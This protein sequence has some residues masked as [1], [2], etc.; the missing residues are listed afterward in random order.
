MPA[1]PTEIQSKG[2]NYLIKTQQAILLESSVDIV[3]GLNWD[4]KEKKIQQT[5]FVELSINEQKII[6][7]LSD[8]KMHIDS[9]VKELEWSFSKVA[10]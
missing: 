7:F 10:N 3:K 9:I 6:N 5:M 2:Y 4:I 8:K 1:S